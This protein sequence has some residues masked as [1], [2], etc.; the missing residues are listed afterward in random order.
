M[1]RLETLLPTA[2]QAAQAAPPAGGAEPVQIAIATTAAALL[3]GA[4]LYLG[5]GHRSGRTC[6]K[7]VLLK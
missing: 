3:T 6:R 5:L 4:L 7:A 1:L 2:A